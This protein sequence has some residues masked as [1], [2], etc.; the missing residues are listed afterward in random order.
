M[1][2]HTSIWALLRQQSGLVVWVAIVF[3]VLVP[4][5]FALGSLPF[6]DEGIYA[7]FSQIIHTYLV[8]EHRLPDAGHLSVYPLL[9]AWVYATGANPLLLL[10]IQDAGVAVIAGYVFFHALKALCRNYWLA[11]LLT[12]A[13]MSTMNQFVFVQA[14]FKNSMFAAYIP[15]FAAYWYAQQS[16]HDNTWPICGVLVAFAVVLR[17]SFAPFALLGAAASLVAGGLRASVRYT[18]AGL[19]TG[20]VLIGSIAWS[21]GSISGLMAAYAE[22]GIIFKSMQAQAPRLFADGGFAFVQH[23]WALLGLAFFAFLYLGWRAIK[24][25][26]APFTGRVLFLSFAALLPLIEPILKIGFPYH[27]AVMLPAMAGLVTLAGKTLLEQYGHERESITIT[28]CLVAA[29]VLF[30][31]MAPLNKGDM[32]THFLLNRAHQPFWPEELTD[33]SN[34]LY[35]AHQIRQHA[36]PGASL[37]TSGWMNA[38]HP[39]TG[40][41]PTS[42]DT[43]SLTATTLRY[44]QNV[45]AIRQAIMVCPP[46]L[47]M[48]TTR[49]D[50]PGHAALQQAV[51]GLGNYRLVAEVPM[52]PDR[53]YGNFGGRIYKSNTPSACRHF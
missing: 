7:F 28:S 20:M 8:T 23:A 21:R 39:L 18:V 1:N 14:G 52:T 42:A 3:A 50:W 46:D 17:E 12:V 15:L 31:N 27:F 35:A 16:E 32:S 26:L 4:R 5:W 10:R 41:L 48:T 51:E 22:S 25:P 11:L 44:S 2:L 19:L 9:S 30:Q 38:L 53:S 49:T 6:T 29:L 34:Y 47:I 40:L 24:T 36:P 13:C 45:Q 43:I 37:A 33:K